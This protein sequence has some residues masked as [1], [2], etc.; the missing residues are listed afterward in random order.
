MENVPGD[1]L[2]VAVT[3]EERIRARSRSTSLEALLARNSED[4]RTYPTGSSFQRFG[5]LHGQPSRGNPLTSFNPSTGKYAPL[6]P[7]DEEDFC[8]A[9]ASPLSGQRT[10]HQPS[11]AFEP[12]V[13]LPHLWTPIWLRKWALALFAA[14]FATFMITIIVLWAISRNHNG[15]YAKHPHDHPFWYYIPTILLVLTAAAWRQVDYHVKSLVPWDQLQ[16][17][18]VSPQQSLLLDYIS[19]FQLVSIFKAFLHGHIPVVASA[20]AFV[21]L[22]IMMIFSTALFL[23]LPTHVKDSR[24]SLTTT[25]TFE[26]SSF[27][28]SGNLSDVTSAPVYA[29]YAGLTSILPFQQGVLSDLAYTTVTYANSSTSSP[30][31]KATITADV[32][33]FMPQMD[34]QPVNAN[35][36]QSTI[37]QRPTSPDVY[38]NGSIG[39]QLPSNDICQSWGPISIQALDPQIDI[40]PQRQTTGTFQ[41]VYCAT[42]DGVVDHSTGPA[43]LLYTVANI[44]YEQD[45]YPGASSLADGSST[46]AINSSRTIK[47]LTNVLCQPSYTITNVTVTNDTTS[48][49]SQSNGVSVKPIFK[50][51]N[52]TLENLSTWNLTTIFA[53]AVSAADSIFGLVYDDDIQQASYT[54]FTL[55]AKS[56]QTNNISL[57]LDQDHL[58]TAAS[59]TF[60]GIMSQYASQ[61]LRKPAS[62]KA[63]GTVEFSEERYHVNG[64]SAIAVIIGLAGATTSAIVLVFLAPRAVVPR[65]PNSIAPIATT[66]THSFELNRLLHRKGVPSLQNQE[67]AL[68][69]YEFGTAIAFTEPDEP[70]FKIVTSEGVPS[71]SRPQ[72]GDKLKWWHPI[73]A[74]LY[75]T[76]IAVTV[77][78][79]L[80][81]LLGFLQMISDHRHGIYAVPDNQET[82]IFTHFIP[83][84]VMLI[85]ASL[86]N[87]VEFNIEL[88]AP[89]SRLAAGHATH[90]RSLLMNFLGKSPPFAFLEAIKTRQFNVLLAI[91][92]TTSACILTIII[93]GL[94]STDDFVSA[95]APVA[96]NRADQFTLKWSDSFSNDNGAAGLLSLI[97]HQN[98]PWPDFTYDRLA[99]PTFSS[100]IDLDFDNK[101]TIAS[102]ASLELPANVASLNCSYVDETGISVYTSTPD[103]NAFGTNMSVVT[104]T[105]PL[106]ENC[107]R[108]GVFQSAYTFNY[109]ASFALPAGG[110]P[111]FGGRQF[112]LTFGDDSSYYGNGG[113]YNGQYIG[114]NPPVGCP[115]IAFTF[116]Q[117]QLGS[118]NTSKVTAMI[119]YQQIYEVTADVTLLSNTTSIDPSHPPVLHDPTAASLLSNPLATNDRIT[120][121]DFRIQENIAR[122]YSRFPNQTDIHT[123]Y[124]SY[125]SGA[126]NNGTHSLSPSSLVG[127]SNRQSLYDALNLFYSR[128]MTQAISLNMRES[129]NSSSSSSTLKARHSIGN[130][131]I[132]IAPLSRRQSP[133]TKIGNLQTTITTPRLLQNRGS[134]LALQILLGLTGGLTAVAWSI[135]KTHK[136]LPCNPCSIAGTM[137]LLAGSDL[138]HN[139]EEE[140]RGVCECCGKP[141]RRNSVGSTAGTSSETIYADPDSDDNDDDRRNSVRAGKQ[142]A[143]QQVIPND[144]EW[145]GLHGFELVFAGKRYSMG[146]WRERKELGRPRR[147]GVDIGNRADGGDDEDW[148]LG[149]KKTKRAVRGILDGVD[150]ARSA[151]SSSRGVADSRGE[152]DQLGKKNTEDPNPSSNRNKEAQNTHEREEEFEEGDLGRRMNRMGSR[153][154]GRDGM[155][156]G[157]NGVSRARGVGGEA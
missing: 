3:E 23:H 117:L 120:T 83:A 33:A 56:Y 26:A 104:I 74:S 44:A 79:V 6:T 45:L 72:S 127:T 141:R 84:L 42:R 22:K 86:V 138:C 113:E 5:S 95:I 103:Q 154:A 145:L 59:A 1:Y 80:I 99:F 150:L 11:T 28:P 153:G 157:T 25:S 87:L 49:G 50:A 116:G 61:T 140:D 57:F 130:T 93:P 55:M 53:A 8:P 119:C 52:Q 30:P 111:V 131:A 60:K 10:I 102:P 43:A 121:F 100:S 9:P 54:L 82:D 77:P 106:P 132:T 64:A 81:G 108:N 58:S 65:D 152:Y 20:S 122:Q 17:G 47:T 96:M 73:T 4:D 13:P 7:L 16:H 67:S 66:L 97:M 15:W 126:L 68:D 128:Y 105:A 63:R 35:A 40:T 147:F 70:S 107:F 149:N 129:T 112:D 91:A 39:L 19:P 144:T 146:W 90:R 41:A 24:S 118:Y 151:M 48:V 110:E 76:L 148:E 136:V 75:F 88:F 98:L 36:N 38:R 37:V 71:V 78:L 139:A 94:Y 101:S 12:L 135:G 109:Q 14:V 29:F 114:D 89:W 2:Q 92:A 115:S 51:A 31:A 34:C 21:L 62:N 123:D 69:G 18:P 85:V 125:F 156:M 133:S 134:T 137:A 32:P 124:D 143:R 27:D 46:I 142:R 155:G